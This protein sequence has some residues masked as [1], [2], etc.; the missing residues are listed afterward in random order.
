MTTIVITGA[1]RGIGYQLS[2][3]FAAQGC[4]VLATARNIDDATALKKLQEK[5]ELLEIFPLDLA[6]QDSIEAFTAALQDRSIDILINNAGTTGREGHGLEPGT[7][8]RDNLDIENWQE[9]MQINCIGPVSLSYGLLENLKSGQDKKVINISSIVGSIP[10]WRG[11]VHNFNL[12]YQTSKAAFSMAISGLS[13]DFNAHGITTVAVHPGWVRTDMGGEHG[14][15]STAQA[16]QR[17]ADLIDALEPQHA[18]CFMVNGDKG[19][20]VIEDSRIAFK[21]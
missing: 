2:E 15:L 18:G 17:I 21:P 14:E 16:V 12:A 11:A 13:D 3:H 10:H 8:S 7:R 4:H 20:E 5:H 19:I 9:A 1:N 6:Q